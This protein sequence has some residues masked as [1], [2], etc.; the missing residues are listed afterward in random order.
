VLDWQP[1]Q[2]QH[3]ELLFSEDEV[4]VISEAPKEKASDTN[5][6]IGLFFSECWEII[7]DDILKALQQFYLLNQ[8]G[9][10]LNQALVVLIPKK[11]HPQKIT[12]Y[13]PISLTHSFVKIISMILANS[14]S[15]ELQ[16]I[17]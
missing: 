5:D 2:L 14:L 13:G 17:I 15:K 1:Q 7:K 8:Q 3:L 12:D 6:F 16:H 4:K 11:E 9:L 10:F